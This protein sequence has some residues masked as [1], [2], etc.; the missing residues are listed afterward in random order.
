MIFE[1][2]ITT[3]RL[4]FE[5]FTA[6]YYNYGKELL[7]DKIVLEKK[8]SFGGLE[9]YSYIKVYLDHSCISK[10]YS[11]NDKYSGADRNANSAGIFS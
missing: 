5:P 1:R 2:V 4:R 3:K 9:T 8:N 11:N 7:R 6:A 10:Y